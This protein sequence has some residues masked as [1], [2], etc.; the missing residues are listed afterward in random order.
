MKCPFCHNLDTQVVDSRTSSD[1]SDVIRRRRSCPACEKRF[2]T[3]ERAELF[4]P[5]LIKRDGSRCEFSRDKLKA[6]IMLALRKRPVPADLID[7]ALSQI[8]E[9]L[10]SSAAKE[11]STEFLGELVMKELKKID[12]VA[13]IRF[14]SVYK[15]FDDLQAFSKEIAKLTQPKK[16]NITS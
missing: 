8:E 15:S 2:T 12:T 10:L 11:V 7:S 3:Y 6:S 5:A 1:S 14:A 16:P 9:Q 13:Y 4:F